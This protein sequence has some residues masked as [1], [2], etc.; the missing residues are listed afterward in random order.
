VAHA[1][2]RALHLTHLTQR[3]TGASTKTTLDC[4]GHLWPDS[5]ETEPA[6]AHSEDA[7]IEVDVTPLQPEHFALASAECRSDR[8][9]PAVP[10]LLASFRMTH[11][12]GQRPA[13]ESNQDGVERRHRV[14]QFQ[15]DGRG[16]LAVLRMIGDPRPCG[17]RAVSR[18]GG[19][20][21]FSRPPWATSSARGVLGLPAQ[22]VTRLALEHLA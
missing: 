13:A 3:V 10:V 17:P 21:R 12:G 7:S 9:S 18:A 2:D 15:A 5:D 20:R 11:A 19:A 8:P 22:H 6:P 1:R 14:H 4:Y 16:A